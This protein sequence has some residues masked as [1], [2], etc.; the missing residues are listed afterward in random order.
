MKIMSYDETWVIQE[1]NCS[2]RS[3]RNWAGLIAG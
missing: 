1:E 3:A 2:S